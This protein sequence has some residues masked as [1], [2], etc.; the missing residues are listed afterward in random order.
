MDTP[1]R[2]KHLV[3]VVLVVFLLHLVGTVY[4]DHRTIRVVIDAVEQ[5]QRNSDLVVK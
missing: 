1:I 2:V 3:Y 5:L 4:E